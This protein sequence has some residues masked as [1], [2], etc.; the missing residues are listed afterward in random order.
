MGSNYPADKGNPRPFHAWF[1]TEGS[2]REY[3]MAIH[4]GFNSFEIYVCENGFITISQQCNI[5]GKEVSVQ[6]PVHLW[7]AIKADIEEGIKVNCK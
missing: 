3:Q 2:D 6:L 4:Q 7:S 1:L 5:I